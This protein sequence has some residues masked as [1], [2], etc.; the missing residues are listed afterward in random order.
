[1]NPPDR[2]VVLCVDEK[3]QIQALDRSL[4][5]L[6]MRLG[7]AERRWHDYIRYGNSTLCAALDVASGVAIGEMHGRHRSAEFRKFLDTVD[8]RVPD[9]LSVHLIMDNYGTHK[10]PLIRRWLV[11]RPRFHVHF[12]PTGGS[13]LNLMERW[14]G[15]LTDERIRRASF[16]STYQLE[17]AIRA[18]VA[19]NNAH[20]K[21]FVWTKSADD[22]LASPARFCG[23]SKCNFSVRTLAPPGGRSGDLVESPVG[24]VGRNPLRC[25]SA[26]AGTSL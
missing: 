5:V 7:Q 16:R 3:S 9:E 8:E 18:Y 17:K 26:D 13:W 12:A 15:I 6:P 23:R 22:I 21:P 4:P 10:T 20:P 19:A 2:A 24:R 25:R 14:F 11:K 1:M